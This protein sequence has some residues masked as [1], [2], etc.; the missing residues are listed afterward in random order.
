[1]D[2]LACNYDPSATDDDGMCE[3]AEALYDCDGNCLNDMDGDGVCD[4]LE[5]E[6][7]T[8]EMA[9]NYDATATDDD[10]SC[11][12]AEEFYDCDGNCLNDIDGDGVCDELEVEGCTDPEAENYN[13]DATEDDGSC[14]YCDIDVIADS[15]N[16]T[17]GDGSGSISLI[18]SGGSFPYEFSWTGP[19]SF[20]SSEPT[21]SNLSAGTYV[22]TITDANGCTASID[23]I[24]ENVVN[25]AEIHALVFDVYP[26][27][28]NGTFWIQG[29][30][31]L[32]GLATVEVMD[33]SGRLVTSK[34]LYFNDAPMQLDLGGVE[35][36][37]YLVVLRNSNQ[38]GTSRLLVH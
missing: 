23:V 8:D 29:G 14:Y 15:S 20:T 28:S 1:M 25:V 36:G 9:C 18:V 27:P 7:C 33:A 3:Y 16:E 13:A 22:L 38:V 10:E 21:L 17:D 30:T 19:D 5:I 37:Y 31:A 32:S 35:T 12:Y 6:G 2:E 4:E 24:I 26:N 34:E 11:T